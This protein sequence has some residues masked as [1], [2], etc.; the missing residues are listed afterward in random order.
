MILDKSD[1]K[2]IRSNQVIIGR[3]LSKLIEDRKN[4]VIDEEDPEKR[5]KM[6][7]W[8]KDLQLGLMILERAKQEKEDKLSGI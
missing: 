7:R 4:Q 3:I 6:R 8:V 1:L 5:E 2:W